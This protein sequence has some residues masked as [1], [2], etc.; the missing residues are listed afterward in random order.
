MKPEAVRFIEQANIMLDRARIMLT[1]DLNEDAAPAAYLACFHAAQAYIFERSDRTAKTHQGVQSEFF[2]LSHVDSRVDQEL[3]RF[4]SRS[5]EFKSI[6]DYFSGSDP[7]VL[8]DEAADSVD[9][10]RRFVDHIGGLVEP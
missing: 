5:Y 6:A 3:R 9:T 7:A 1:V 4:L 10:A 8:P 2:R